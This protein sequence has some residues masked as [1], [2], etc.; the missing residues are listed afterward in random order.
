MILLIL[1]KKIFILHYEDEINV[2]EI[3]AESKEKLF[4]KI[5]RFYLGKGKYTIEECKRYKELITDIADDLANGG[6]NKGL[7]DYY[8]EK[9]PDISSEH[10]YKKYHTTFIT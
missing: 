10:F 9:E 7:F 2:G 8:L 1:R 5:D 3:I 4:S 6:M